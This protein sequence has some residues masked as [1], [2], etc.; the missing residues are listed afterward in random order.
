MMSLN[1]SFLPDVRQANVLSLNVLLL[2]EE[3]SGKSSVGNALIGKDSSFG[4]NHD[5]EM[6]YFLL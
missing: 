6:F 1:K 5:V 2:G 3:Q 4:V